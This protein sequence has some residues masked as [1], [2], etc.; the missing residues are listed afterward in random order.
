MTVHYF[1]IS[2]AQLGRWVLGT[3]RPVEDKTG[4]TEGMTSRFRGRL[5]SRVRSKG[6]FL[7]PIRGPRQPQ[8]PINSA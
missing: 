5:C 2:M 4:L 1:G 8:L 3:A 6:V 7:R